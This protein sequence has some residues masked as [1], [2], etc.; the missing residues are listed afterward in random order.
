M[1]GLREKRQRDVFLRDNMNM[2]ANVVNNS[3]V[4]LQININH[5]PSFHKIN[6]II[7]C[8]INYII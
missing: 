1:G 7:S 4:G 3:W 5:I 8:E 6:H 2:D